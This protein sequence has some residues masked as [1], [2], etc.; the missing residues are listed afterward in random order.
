MCVGIDYGELCCFLMSY[1]LP[2]LPSFYQNIAILVIMQYAH[3]S[4]QE[5]LVALL[6]HLVDLSLHHY[7]DIT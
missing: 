4:T 7:Y 3:H 6:A 5:T 1:L 2:I